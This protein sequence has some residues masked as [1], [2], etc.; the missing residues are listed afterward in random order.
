MMEIEERQLLVDEALNRGIQ[1]EPLLLVGSLPCLGNQLI[2]ARM[3]ES[4][5]S[6]L[7]RWCTGKELPR[8]PPVRI[9]AIAAR[10]G[11]RVEIPVAALFVQ[12]S[13]FI[14]VYHHFETDLAPHGLHEFGDVLCV[15]ESKGGLQND[16]GSDRSRFTQD[17]PGP[18]R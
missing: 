17:S 12:H 8:K 13:V 7:V 10:R 16:S 3:V 11:I 14:H 5:S 1:L 9:P 4:R 15:G 2:D 18:V 6:K